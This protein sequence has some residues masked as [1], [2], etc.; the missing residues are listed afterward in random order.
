[1]MEHNIF[2]VVKVIRITS[3]SSTVGLLDIKLP[4]LSSDDWIICSDLSKKKNLCKKWASGDK[5]L[6]ASLIIVLNKSL[7]NLYKKLIIHSSVCVEL[8]EYIKCK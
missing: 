3:S 8:C 5:Y 6:T 2:Y 7:L 1:M 4:V